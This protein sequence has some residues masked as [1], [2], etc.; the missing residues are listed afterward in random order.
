MTPQAVTVSTFGGLDLRSD[1]QDDPGALDALNVDFD[2]L[3]RVRTRDG[4]TQ[5]VATG[6][7]S[8]RTFRPYG[9]SGA[10]VAAGIG[11]TAFKVFTSAG[12]TTA[13]GNNSVNGLA[14]SLAQ[15][16]TPGANYVYGGDGDVAGHITRWDGASVTFPN[17]GYNAYFAATT[18]WDN[19]L[20]LALITNPTL[21]DSRV[22][23][24]DPGLPET[25]GANNYVDVTPGDREPIAGVCVWR[26][27][28]FVFKHSRF[29]VFYGVSSDSTG[30]PV[31]NYRTVDVGVGIGVPGSSYGGGC[32]AMEDGV[33]FSNINGLYRTSGG[34]PDKVSRPVDP[35]FK[36]GSAASFTGSVDAHGSAQVGRFR[37]KVL[38]GYTTNSS[39][40][41][42][43]YSTTTGA[44][45]YWDVTARAFLEYQTGSTADPQMLV[46]TNNGFQISLLGPSYTTD[47]GTAI[48]SRYRTG[49]MDLGSPR[50]EKFVRG[51]SLTGT[52][53]VNLKKAVNDTATLSAAQSLTLGTSPAV[54]TATSW[55]GFRGRNMSVEV[56]ATSGAWS[57]S[58]LDFQVQAVRAPGVRSA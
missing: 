46:A 52:G 49:F 32:V 7:N 26:D 40:A 30:Q 39:V 4:Y 20:V 31:F 55:N 28:L 5:L 24:S 8:W 57:L 19:R 12:A 47:N 27:K 3:G 56:G 13:T 41:T 6:G 17:V 36:I 58:E 45:S 21:N 18:P 1:P 38:Y 9:T 25:F 34:P 35:I 14:L 48:A 42:L 23:F 16:A 54:A 53:V 2:T 51:M 11:G 50:S 29:F 10:F 15:I 44:W 22:R 33:Y 43:V 37:D